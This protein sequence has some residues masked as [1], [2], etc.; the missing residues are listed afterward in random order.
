MHRPERT[1]VLVESDPDVRRLLACM[2]EDRQVGVTTFETVDAALAHLLTHAAPS[3][4]VIDARTCCDAHELQQHVRR[5]RRLA[6][7]PLIMLCDR[8]SRVSQ[9]QRVTVVQE[10]LRLSALLRAIERHVADALVA[11]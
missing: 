8:L 9:D 2:L 1:I 10:P 7:L 5:D 3:C 4:V 6:S 11:S